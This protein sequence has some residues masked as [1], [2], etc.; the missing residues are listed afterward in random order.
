MSLEV[1]RQLSTNVVFRVGYVGTKGTSLFQTVDGNP[2]LPFS[3]TRVDPARGVIRLRANSAS[4]IYHSLQVSGEKRLTRNVSAAIHYTLSAFIDDASDVFNA[5][6]GEVAVAQDSFDRRADR[7]RSS[8][9]R[10]SR[11]TGNIVYEFPFFRS[12]RGVVQHILGGWQLNSFF[13]FQ[14]GAPFTVLNGSDPT[15]ALNGI[16]S[17]VGNAIRPN[18]NTTLNTSGMSTEELLAAGG[19]ALYATLPAG[20]RTG[21]VGRNTLRADGIGNVDIGFIKNTRL[22]ENQNVQLRVEMYNATNTRNFGIPE[23]RIN[24]SNFLNQWGTDGGSRRIVIA[25]RYM[26]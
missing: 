14:S 17:L 13:T 5:S 9:D 4:S 6:T 19:R 7:S 22:K 21:N 15:G 3:T 20:T 8:Y 16:D 23:G 25:L 1:Q 24:S 26:F 12:N 10:P 2:R 11:F 18:L